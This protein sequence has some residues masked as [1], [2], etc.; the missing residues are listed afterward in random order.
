MC[1]AWIFSPNVRMHVVAECRNVRGDF[2]L[3]CFRE[4]KDVA[5]SASG[6]FRDIQNMEE[7]CF[8]IPA[9]VPIPQQAT[10]ITKVFSILF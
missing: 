3:V 4:N 2:I 5:V 9:R 7:G 1:G 10:S 6:S 8:R